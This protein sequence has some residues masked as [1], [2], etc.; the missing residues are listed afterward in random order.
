M[1]YTIAL[2][3]TRWGRQETLV[4]QGI[5]SSLKE[6]ELLIFGENNTF[7]SINYAHVRWMK[8]EPIKGVP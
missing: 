5:S 2:Q 7:H 6:G 3:P 4:L 8:A 1:R